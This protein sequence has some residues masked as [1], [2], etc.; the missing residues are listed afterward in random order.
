[1]RAAFY[2]WRSPC[3]L[4]EAGLH[5][6]I[7]AKSVTRPAQTVQPQA[8]GLRGLT[9][10]IKCLGLEH[11]ERRHEGRVLMPL[12]DVD[13]AI[14]EGNDPCCIICRQRKRGLLHCN[15]CCVNLCCAA[16]A[17][18]RLRRR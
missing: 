14:T 10:D 16:V 13:P 4:A 2:F 15:M 7:R 12:G 11:E 17:G 8:L 6:C 3:D 5:V 9:T 1:M 18:R